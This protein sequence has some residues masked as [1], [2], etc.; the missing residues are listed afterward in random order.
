L[1]RVAE[2]SA[3]RRYTRDIVAAL[4]SS[5]RDAPWLEN[6]ATIGSMPRGDRIAISAAVV[7]R[8]CGYPDCRGRRRSCEPMRRELKKAL[9]GVLK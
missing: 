9:M 3:Q 8:V 6:I 1:S 2:L 4:A 7:I 5:W